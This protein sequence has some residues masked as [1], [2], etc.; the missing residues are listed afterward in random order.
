M[1]AGAGAILFISGEPGIGKSRLLA[2]AAPRFGAPDAERAARVA[3]GPLRLVRRV[4]AVLAVPRPAARLA[5][6]SRST[7]PSCASRLALRRAVDQL[8]GDRADELYPYLG[9]PARP[10]RSS[11]RPRA[12]LAELS[13]EALQYRTFE[14]VRAPARAARREAA[15][16]SSRSR[17]STGP[18]RRRCSSPSGC[19]RLTEDAAVLLV[20]TQRPDP[21][22]PSWAAARAAPRGSC[23]HRLRAIDARGPVGRR[24]ARAAPR[25]RRRGHA[26]GR[27]RARGCSTQ[28]E[29]NPFFLEE[30]V[31]SLVDAGRA[32]SRRR[33]AGASTTRSPSRSRRPSRR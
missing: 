28:A 16:S 9:G 31:R 10:D 21:D 23:P 19:C 25:A 30:L 18:T 24:R 26:A 5:R 6:R 11:P 15:R 8:L 1:L 3:R 17:T 2:R 13:P 7:I 33:A 27:P 22:H 14:V 4:D 12:R 32:R 20:I 29:G